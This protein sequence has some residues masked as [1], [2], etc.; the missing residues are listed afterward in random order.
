MCG[1]YG[2][3]GHRNGVKIALDGLKRIEYRG[4]DSAGLAAITEGKLEYF[5][6]VGKLSELERLVGD[7]SS[8]T[9]IA[10]TRWATHG[11]VTRENAHP[12][13]D[14]SKNIAVVFNGIIEN[15]QLLKEKLQQEGVTFV[16]ET[17]T[18]VLPHLI[19]RIYD[20][21]FL[22]AVQQALLLL[23][24]SYA[25]AILHRDHPNEM[26]VAAHSC[27]LVIGMAAQETF[28]SSD[29]NALVHHT[30]EVIYLSD[31]EVAKITLEGVE[32][33]DA[34][35]AQISKET[36][37]ILH[38]V[39]ETT[40]GNF[41]HYTLKEIF[42]Q[43]QTIR[44]AM[45]SRFFEEYGTVAIDG[46][47]ISASDLLSI[48]RFLIVSCG[49]SFHAGLV[50][51]YM[52]ED[53]AG[54]PTQ[55]EIS[56]EFR[57]KNP[58][59]QE[60][61]FVIAISQSGETADTI[62]AV[63]EIKAKGAKILAV[64]NVQGSTLARE[65]DNTLFLRAGPEIGVCSTKAFTSQLAVL[66]LFAL[67]MAR[68]KHMSKLEGQNFL[69]SLQ[70]LPEQVQ[71]VLDLAPQIEKIAKKYSRYDHFF[72]LGRRYMYPTA[73]EAALKLKEIAYVNAN[74]YPAGEMKHGP[75]AL[76]DE[77]C[78][79]VALCADKVTFDKLLSN[80]MEVKARHGKVIAIA[81]EGAKGL[82]N[83]VDEVIY[84]PDTTDELAPILSTVAAQLFA[85]YVAKER[86]AEIDRPRNLAKSVTVE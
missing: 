62:A 34:T 27:P 81:H 32:I 46:L 63:R 47:H 24:G 15:Y 85:Y 69:H 53:L 76:I 12:Q 16:S 23:H 84:V 30:R 86:G 68:T 8:P 28:V 26:I 58:I 64:C 40:K 29:P 21:D 20:G 7:L 14:E 73:L 51:G 71:R 59:V 52:L 55:V 67:L 80:L 60:G 38:S 11:R 42:E 22:K 49:T 37:Q 35:L 45:L 75:I 83:T 2:Y 50:A 43:P 57:Y 74:G 79:T 61:T 5:K 18:E 82:E 54:V 3:L 1:I 13:L 31:G 19:A 36:E 10:H 44:N 17:D 70:K 66:S 4:Y 78:P 41:E 56:S 9:V 39:E 33:F 72:F 65:A 77:E 25:C 48:K 6:E